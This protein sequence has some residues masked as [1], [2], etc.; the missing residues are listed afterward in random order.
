MSSLYYQHMP[1]RKEGEM[2]QTF[3]RRMLDMSKFQKVKRPDQIH[4]QEQ[5]LPLPRAISIP[6]ILITP[7]VPKFRPIRWY[8]FPILNLRGHWLS[9][10]TFGLRIFPPLIAQGGRRHMSNL[11]SN[12][13]RWCRTTVDTTTS[14]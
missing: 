7:N 11:A 10:W 1:M 4:A 6:H 3:H 5:P 13:A 12:L 2:V 8:T 9:L 14:R